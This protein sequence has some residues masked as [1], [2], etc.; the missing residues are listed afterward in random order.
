MA[1]VP[2]KVKYD[3]MMSLVCEKHYEHG[4]LVCCPFPGCA[5]GTDAEE[6]EATGPHLPTESY[7]RVV[8][9]LPGGEVCYSG[10]KKVIRCALKSNEYC[11]VKLHGVGWLKDTHLERGR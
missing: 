3:L 4:P 10:V 9:D 7:R 1:T 2:K 5:N 8:W 6:I 11:L